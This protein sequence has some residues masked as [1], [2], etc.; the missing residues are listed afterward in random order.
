MTLVAGTLSLVAVGGNYAQVSSTP[1]VGGVG[2]YTYQW[3]R[4]TS[5]GFS[6]GG[7]NIIPGATSLTLTD[8]GLISSTTYFYKLVSTDTGN[9]NDT[10]TSSQLSATTTAPT[11]NPNQFAMD[12]TLGMIDLRF[13]YNSVSCLVDISQA[14]A[15][16][17]GSAV[18]MVDS[19]GGVPKVVGVTAQS[20]EVLGFINFDIKTVAFNAGSPCEISMA[21][22]VVFLYA[23][24]PIPRGAQVVVG[25]LTVHPK[26]NTV[27]AALGETGDN[28]VGWAYDKATAPGELIRVFLK[29]PSFTVVS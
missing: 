24:E 27:A 14:T 2:P 1:A 5:T 16:Y 3:Y 19:A 20:D 25:D 9:S 18:K 8:T 12:P 28:I 21:G 17:A 15:L 23:A 29:T 26:G 10:I 7:G 22:N 13:P 4:S 11:L 6:P